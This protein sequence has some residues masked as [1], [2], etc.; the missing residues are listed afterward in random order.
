MITNKKVFVSGCFDLLH[1]GHIKF[2]DEAS[3]FG[4]V[5]V[6]IGSDETVNSLKGRFPVNNEQER[7]YMLES[8]KTVEKVVINSGSGILDFDPEIRE[9]KPDLLIVNEDGNTM[10]KEELCRNLG[11]E[12]VVMERTPSSG[13]PSR[14]STVLREECTIPFRVDL[15]GGWHDHPF[16]SNYAPGYVITISVEPTIEFNDRSGMASST[17]RMAKELWG[18]SIPAGNKEKLAKI[19]FSYENP[20]GTKEV[21]GS[22][23]SIGIVYPGLNKLKYNG[24]Y[25]PESIESILDE[26]VLTFIENHVS[27]ISLGPRAQGLEVIQEIN[28]TEEKA[29]RLAKASSDCWESLLNKDIRNLGRSVTESFESQTAIIPATTNDEIIK[30]V[31]K[32]K[33]VTLGLKLAGAGGGGYMVLVSENPIPGTIKIKIRR[34]DQI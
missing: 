11:I 15:A 33:D 10:A 1:S 4:S 19:L 26:D 12:Y 25:W 30:M 7:K 32:Y 3:K 20:P 14:S 21:S 2:L 9:L 24:D 29:N 34:S 17:R 18:N 13:L 31:N 22:Q 27:L 28:C 8:L 16:I 6:G 23:D 5:I